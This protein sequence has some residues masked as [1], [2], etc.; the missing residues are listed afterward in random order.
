MRQYN[1]DP[2][3]DAPSGRTKTS[4]RSAYPWRARPWSYAWL[5]QFDR[6]RLTS[7]ELAIAEQMLHFHLGREGHRFRG[8]SC[9]DCSDIAGAIR[10]ADK[11]VARFQE[12]ALRLFRSVAE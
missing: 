4:K 5:A 7:P 8:S 12:V 1:R 11:A 6:D 2:G 10:V 3:E 9:Y